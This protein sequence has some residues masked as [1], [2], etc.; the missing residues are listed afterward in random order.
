MFILDLQML[1]L[2]IKLKRWVKFYFY[3]RSTNYK[4][5]NRVYVLRRKKIWFMTSIN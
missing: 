2:K 3:T 1:L 4:V 5:D